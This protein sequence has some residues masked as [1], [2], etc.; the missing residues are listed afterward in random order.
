MVTSQKKETDILKSIIEASEKEASTVVSKSDSGDV[1]GL[2]EK[3]LINIIDSIMPLFGNRD[4]RNSSKSILNFKNKRDESSVDN[5]V[6]LVRHYES[7]SPLLLLTPRVNTLGFVPIDGGML[8]SIV[9]KPVRVTSGY[10]WRESYHR[11]HH[12]IDVAC[13]IGDTIYALYDGKVE[14]VGDEPNGYGRYVV[15]SHDDDIETRYAHLL[16]S[17]VH[18]EQI[19]LKGDAIAISGNSGNSTG[20]HLHFEI[21]KNGK[22]FNP[23]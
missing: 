11:I 20:P 9:K 4:V 15:L 19:V 17:L 8:E 18:P 13:S 14:L 5:L 6:M 12:G 10:G 2:K 1:V 3:K 16:N 22:P 7:K 21:R 23:L